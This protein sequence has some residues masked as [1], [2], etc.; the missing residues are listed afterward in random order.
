MALTAT[1]NKELRNFSPSDQSQ[2]NQIKSNTL[3]QR[4]D[5]DFLITDMRKVLCLKKTFTRKNTRLPA[6]GDRS[7]NSCETCRAWACVRRSIDGSG[8]FRRAAFGL[9]FLCDHDATGDRSPAQ[10]PLHKLWRVAA[11]KREQVFFAGCLL[12]FWLINATSLSGYIIPALFLLVAMGRLVRHAATA[13]ATC[14]PRRS[15]LRHYIM[16][17]TSVAFFSLLAVRGCYFATVIVDAEFRSDPFE[18]RNSSS[19]R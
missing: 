10:H 3:L 8:S 9:L 11:P 18:A 19:Q 13:F 7:G 15:Q 17:G 4:Q 2:Q 1:G 16:L 5:L 6:S 14:L 12:M